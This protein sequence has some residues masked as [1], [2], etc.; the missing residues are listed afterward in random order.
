M[1]KNYII[2]GLILIALANTPAQAMRH[3]G[4]FAFLTTLK[5]RFVS[6]MIYNTKYQSR[7]YTTPA[8]KPSLFQRLRNYST[9]LLF[10][11]ATVGITA[12]IVANT[13]KM[14]TK[15]TVTINGKTISSNGSIT[16]INGKIISLPDFTEHKETDTVYDFNGD[17]VIVENHFGNI[18]VN[19]TDHKKIRIKTKMN[20][21]KGH[22]NDIKSHV[23][24]RGNRCQIYT[25]GNKKLIEAEL[26]YEIEMPKRA[27]VKSASTNG[28]VTVNGMTNNKEL[29]TTNGS[30][31]A[32]NIEGNT[33]TQTTNGGTHIRYRNTNQGT[34]HANATN[35]AI[36]IENANTVYAKTTN[37]SIRVIYAR[38]TKNGGNLKTTNGSI[39]TK[40]A[41]KDLVYK[42][43]NGSTSIN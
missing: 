23:E 43:K 37:G 36:V 20:S 40:N 28:T 3:A 5:N 41:P 24:I 22:E 42:T 27:T 15:S 16:I 2:F 7:L 39:K 1:N 34:T 31:S 29:V 18:L 19:G 17:D 6:A 35:G 4:K 14:K 11:T 30:L 26:D 25:Q 10:G 38:N 33:T 21:S 13:N 8:G 9:R 32:D 12:G